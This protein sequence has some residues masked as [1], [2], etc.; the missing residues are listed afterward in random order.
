MALGSWLVS[1][2]GPVAWR[3]IGSLGLGVVTYV[4]VDAAVSAA[5][6]TAQANWGQLGGVAAQLVGLSGLNEALSV[7]A[8]GITA[9]ISFMSLKRFVLK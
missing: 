9:R 8:G 4:G 5:L 3:V 6:S 7:I 1:L 2:A